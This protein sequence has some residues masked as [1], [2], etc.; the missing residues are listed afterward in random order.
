MATLVHHSLTNCQAV[1][2]SRG[3][4]APPQPGLFARVG[5]TL[6]GVAAPRARATG[7]GAAQRARTARHA[8]VVVRCLARN[9]PAVLARDAAV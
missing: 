9:P 3:F 6:A 4:A 2:L 7:T 5:A 8:R 1:P